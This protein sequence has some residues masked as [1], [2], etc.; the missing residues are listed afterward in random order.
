MSIRHGD[1]GLLCRNKA[2]P[3]PLK[4]ELHIG[5]YRNGARGVS[6]LTMYDDVRSDI[7]E[8]TGDLKSITIK[9]NIAFDRNTR[10]LRIKKQPLFL[11]PLSGT[12]T[13]LAVAMIPGLT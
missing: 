12:Q 7:L 2:T 6:A 13:P 10:H 8:A 9:K 3:E 4:H 5:K 1:E 11:E